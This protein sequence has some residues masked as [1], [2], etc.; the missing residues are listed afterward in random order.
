MSSDQRTKD[1]RTGKARIV[2][3]DMTIWFR[4]G[5]YPG[6]GG[7]VRYRTLLGRDAPSYFL[8]DKIEAVR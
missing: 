6:P 2:W 5:R 4:W 1:V 3:H 8:A 7:F